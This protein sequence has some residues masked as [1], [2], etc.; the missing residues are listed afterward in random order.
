M[1]KRMKPFFSYNFREGIVS[2]CLIFSLICMFLFVA[3]F[4]PIIAEGLQITITSR[5]VTD[6]VWS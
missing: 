5:R 3:V 4:A 2:N 1:H 6:N